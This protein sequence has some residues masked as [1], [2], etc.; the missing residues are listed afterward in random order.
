MWDGKSMNGWL[1][2]RDSKL[3]AKGWTILDNEVVANLKDNKGGGDIVTDKE[4]KNFILEIDFKFTPRANGGIKY[5][6]QPNPREKDFQIS[7]ANIKFWTT[8]CIRMLKRESI[9]TVRWPL[10]TT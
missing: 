1:N 6:I 7:A 5:F 3:P 8:N 2:A 10:C 9:A 4:Y